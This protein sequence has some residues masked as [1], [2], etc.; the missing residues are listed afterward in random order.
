[1]KGLVLTLDYFRNM[2]TF[3]NMITIHL[4]LVQ[5]LKF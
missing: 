3:L 4:A 1:M 2:T 5:Y